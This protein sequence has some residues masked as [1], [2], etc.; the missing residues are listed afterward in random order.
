MT[1]AQELTRFLDEASRCSRQQ[2]LF[3]AAIPAATAGLVGTEVLAG[4]APG[5]LLPLLALLL[6]LLAAA[7][8]DSS[9]V[10]FLLLILG[11]HWAMVVPEQLSAWVLLAGAALLA[12]HVGAAL[13]SYGPPSLVLDAGLVRLWGVRSG[14][15]LAT[16]V[17][18]WSAARLLSVLHLPASGLVLGAALA[19]LTA[20]TW[21]L[22]RRL[23]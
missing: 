23:T 3:R 12:I 20:W 5:T 10:L 13:A 19:L 8:P 11:V 18:T 22:T 7:L 1:P 2:L 15:L 21:L 6:A 17:L 4:A 16:M 14:V 9:A